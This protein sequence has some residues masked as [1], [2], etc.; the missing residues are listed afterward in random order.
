MATE[1][2]QPPSSCSPASSATY[3]PWVLLEHYGKDKA[4]GSHT[5]TDARTFATARSPTGHLVGVSLRL[6]APPAA[7]SI[8]VYYPDGGFDIAGSTVVAAHEDS[9]L[10]NIGFGEG[11]HH[12]TS[13]YFVYNAGDAGANPPRAPSLSL[14]PPY[15]LTKEEM[16]RIHNWSR[17]EEEGTGLLRR[18]EDEIAVAE[19][20]IVPASNAT[21]NEQMEAELHLFRSGQWSVVRPALVIHG[22][23]HGLL[24]LWTTHTVL[25]VGDT[26]VCWVSLHH[27]LLFCS[28]FDESPVLRH[29]PLPKQAEEMEPHSGP[30]SSRDVC[31]T[32]GSMVKFVGIFP[33]CCCGGTGSTHCQHS[34][35]AYTINTWTLSMDSMVWVMDGMV[36]GTELWGLHAYEGLP[37][38]PLMLPIVSL[39]D[40][41]TICFLACEWYHIRDSGDITG[42]LILVDIKRKA[43]KSV[44]RHSDG[45]LLTDVGQ[46]LP[47]RVSCYLDSNQRS[48]NR[49]SSAG[50]G[51]MDMI[52]SSPIVVIDEPRA[53]DAGSS[54]LSSCKSSPK[55]SIMQLSMVL[56]AFLEIQSYDLDQDDISKAYTILSHDGRRLKSFLG[57]PNNL[58]KDWILVEIKATKA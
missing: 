8:C 26:Q 1:P 5:A 12:N 55:P 20:T 22:D 50:E 48:S 18:G 4:T 53:N 7:S 27:G 43:I 3:P 57:L 17:L 45:R 52:P 34:R 47:S 37:R 44:C 38:I 23:S 29:V 46:L 33:R 2:R 42:W 31:I 10:I 24:S 9:V 19:L 6:A 49:V 28:V 21:T 40:P 30:G 15:Y 56:A 25:P 16:E 36:H 58:R 41:H 54:A 14:L 39:V 13:D 51:H 11:Y 35:H 32:S